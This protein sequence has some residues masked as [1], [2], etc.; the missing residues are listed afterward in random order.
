MSKLLL[1]IN[2]AEY[3]GFTEISVIDSIETLS[4]S[5]NFTSTNTDRIPFPIKDGDPCRITI[6]DQQILTGFIDRVEIDSGA[7]SHTLLVQGR[8]KTADVVDSDAVGVDLKGSIDL[9]DVIKTT[10]IISSIRLDVINLAGEIE[11]FKDDELA[12]SEVGENCFEFIEKF[13]RKRQVLLTSDA[14]GNITLIRSGNQEKLDIALLKELHGANNNIKSARVSYDRSARYFH[15]IVRSQGNP[16]SGLDDPSLESHEGEVVDNEIRH[17]RTLE[18]QAESLSDNESLTDRAKWE[19]NFRRAR[20]FQYTCSVKGHFIDPQ[21][22]TL[23]KPNKIVRVKD[24]ISFIDGDLLIKQV[25]YTL[26]NRGGAVTNLTCV[27]TDAYTLQA[28]RDFRDAEV[29]DIGL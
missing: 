19:S 5:F 15:Y 3:D 23:W 9:V 4:K 7:Q 13:C 21:E 16:V 28:E 24:D 17:G 22:T 2:G 11:G 12:T 25:Q 10:L 29:D 8:D 1:E 14:D 27:Y 18:I 20:G 26:D 6:N